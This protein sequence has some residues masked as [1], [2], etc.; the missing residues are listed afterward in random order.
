MTF[1]PLKEEEKWEAYLIPGLVFH[2]FNNKRQW[3]GYST[4]SSF[5]FFFLL[6]KKTEEKKAITI[7][8]KRPDKINYTYF[9]FFIFSST[10]CLNF[11]RNNLKENV[12]IEMCGFMGPRDGNTFF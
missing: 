1:C 12:K 7:T 4:T 11:K 2:P 9:Y 3:K 10:G 8:Q 6:Q 5:N